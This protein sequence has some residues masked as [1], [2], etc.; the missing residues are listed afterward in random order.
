MSRAPSKAKENLDRDG[1]R[2]IHGPVNRAFCLAGVRAVKDS[3]DRHDGL[4]FYVA[5]LDRY[6]VGYQW[7]CDT[8]KLLMNII[9]ELRTHYE[10]AARMW[11]DYEERLTNFRSAVKNDVA[12]VEASAR[13]TT[14]AVQRM[15]KAYSEV[16]AQLNSPSMQQAIQNAERLAAAMESLSALQSHKLVFAVTDQ[17]RDA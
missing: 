11:K 16:M 3:R 9:E 5:D 8:E 2:D 6:K 10:A 4:A 12:S 1:L 7:A 14:E 17:S 13:K 15:N